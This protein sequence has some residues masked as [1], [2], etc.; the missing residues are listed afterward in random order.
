MNKI[1]NLGNA[2]ILVIFLIWLFAVIYLISIVVAAF[3]IA[4]LIL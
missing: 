1:F 2:M 3:K 4:F